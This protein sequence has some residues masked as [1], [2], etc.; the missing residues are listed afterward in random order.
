[1]INPLIHIFLIA[2][3]GG[4]PGLTTMKIPMDS[5]QHC[6]NA[7]KQIKAAATWNGRDHVFSS[8]YA[9]CIDSYVESPILPVENTNE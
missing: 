4:Q 8:S 9:F 3:F 5:M 7:E 1:M 6:R 2:S